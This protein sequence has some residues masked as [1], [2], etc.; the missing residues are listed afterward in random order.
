M[1]GLRALARS[2]D[3]AEVAAYTDKWAAAWR[4]AT[5]EVFPTDLPFLDFVHEIARDPASRTGIFAT[6]T[7]S[8]KTL[9][10]PDMP[11]AQ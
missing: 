4:P 9:T 6:G 1:L 11:G 3:S 8:L 10:L 2:A 5:R 7:R